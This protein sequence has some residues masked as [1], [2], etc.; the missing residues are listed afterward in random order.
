M[1]GAIVGVLMA[2]VVNEGTFEITCAQVRGL[3]LSRS[4]TPQVVDITNRKV[5][6]DFSCN[7]ITFSRR[8]CVSEVF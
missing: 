8:C 2:C 4:I 7:Q 6:R 5:Y 3:T 1:L